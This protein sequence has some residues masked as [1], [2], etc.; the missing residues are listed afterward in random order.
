VTVASQLKQ[1][2]KVVMLYLDMLLL[3][4]AMVRLTQTWA[5]LPLHVEFSWTLSGSTEH[6]RSRYWA[7]FGRYCE[8]FPH[9]KAH[10]N[11]LV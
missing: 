5:L 1:L 6:F 7:F 2:P 9:T 3:V 4:A 10:T 8:R 11:Y